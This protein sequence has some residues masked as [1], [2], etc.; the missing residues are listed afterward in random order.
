MSDEHTHAPMK[1]P[2]ALLLSALFVLASFAQGPV[3]LI[4]LSGSIDVPMSAKKSLMVAVSELDPNGR[5]SID[6]HEVKVLIAADVDPNAVIEALD[7]AGGGALA[8]TLVND[9][10]EKTVDLNTSAPVLIDTGDPEADEAALRAAKQ[11]W[12]NTDPAAHDAHVQSLRQQQ[13][14]PHAE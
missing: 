6:G 3:R 9:S 14:T 10:R 8:L 11:A 1:R 12:R 4:H 7:A 2:Y 13:P 5:I